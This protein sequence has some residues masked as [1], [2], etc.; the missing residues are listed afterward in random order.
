MPLFKNKKTRSS[1]RQSLTFSSSRPSQPQQRPPPPRAGERLIHP[2]LAAPPGPIYPNSSSSDS[3]NPRLDSDTSYTD[4]PPE[5]Y[6]P[7]YD[8]SGVP[9]TDELAAPYPN[10]PSAQ[11]QPPPQLSQPSSLYRSQ[12]SRQ[13]HLRHPDPQR[14]QT[15]PH[16]NELDRPSV[17]LVAHEE[18]PHSRP[19]PP[20]TFLG[21]PTSGVLERRLSVKGKSLS[22]STS[23]PSSPQIASPPRLRPTE[24]EPYSHRPSHS[25]NSSPT[26]QQHPPGSRV[27]SLPL[28]QQRYQP[29]SRDN[30]ESLR[31]EQ[32]QSLDRP[33]SRSQAQALSHSQWQ[34]PSPSAA[35]TLQEALELPPPPPLNPA[36][37]SNTESILVHRPNGRP[38]PTDI[39]AA[40]L[41]HDQDRLGRRAHP[42]ALRAK[43][44]DLV[45]SARPPSQHS[46]EASSRGKLANRPD[47]M[48]QAASKSPNPPVSQLT[49][50]NQQSQLH[51]P[52]QQETQGLPSAQE[53]YSDDSH[54]QVN[55]SSNMADS[56]GSTPTARRGGEDSA[57]I[58]VQVL[59]QKY[60][61]LQTKYSKVK[62]YYFDKD[63]QVQHLQNTVAHQRMAVS[64]TVLDDN[65][66]ANRFTRLDGAIKDLA[67]SVRKDWRG[68]PGWLHGLVAEEA[69][70]KEMTAA[71]R[72]VI[73]RWLVEEVFHRHLHPGLDPTL[74][75]QLKSIEMNLRRQQVR[76]PTEEERE[77]VLVRIS[78][79]R[80]TTFDGLGDALSAPSAQK[81]RDELV[82]YLTADLT[83]FLSGQL[84]ESAQPGLEAAVRM[85]IESSVNITEKIPLEARDVSVEYFLPNSSF[86][87]TCMKVDG[88]LPPLAHPPSPPPLAT[89]TDGDVSTDGPAPETCDA[90]LAAAADSGSS[91]V[92]KTPRKSVLGALMGRR[93]LGSAT[94]RTPAGAAPHEENKSQPA[95]E[96]REKHSRIRFASFLAIEVRGKGSPVVLV[97]A[98]VWLIE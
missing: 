24:D 88:V 41:S 79:W 75:I 67:F 59:K 91:V 33:S 94:G 85:I 36:R 63:A 47:A 51:L 82:D 56:A 58:D 77:N 14:Q 61:E 11:H 15:K 76:P 81:H 70:A 65:E 2:A 1:P 31:Q 16:E 60:E 50:H 5:G 84:H 30:S 44:Q 55:P 80:R 17:K 64:R 29:P 49:Q 19:L 12:S 53:Q 27:S 43:Q 96:D 48:Q 39:P 73:S 38:G 13:P 34:T 23:Q 3:V 86:D 32:P 40:S 26:D 20:R 9:S 92:Q 95:G 54:R 10:S 8:G 6:H 98:P 62:R 74:S 35:L 45:Q 46:L 57:E 22:Y 21:R 42:P 28:Q 69:T 89:P 87:E 72:A 71:G 97:K 83:A 18:S 4:L 90:S 93:P 52:Q 7:N 68:V 66:Y 78:N 25:S 37:R